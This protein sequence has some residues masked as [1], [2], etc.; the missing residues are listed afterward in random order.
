[1]VTRV[2]D[3]PRLG[4]TM[5]EGRIVNWLVKTGDRFRR[6]DVLLEI[7]TDKTVVE[8]PALGDGLL[9]ERLATEGNGVEDRSMPCKAATKANAA[10]PHS[11]K[12]PKPRRGRMDARARSGWNGTEP[13]SD[14]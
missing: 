1:M 11:K 2:L 6:G 10:A 7:E 9:Q 13:T 4:E 12:R 3:M 8:Y 14:V 5:E